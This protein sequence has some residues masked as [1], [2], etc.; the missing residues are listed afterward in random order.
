MKR[1]YLFILL[2]LL[3]LTACNQTLEEGV[4]YEAI[5]SELEVSVSELE[6]QWEA[7]SQD[8]RITCNSY[9]AAETKTSWLSLS[10]KNGKGNGSLQVVVGAN[11]SGTTQR[12]G[13][14]EITDG[15]RTIQVN[16]S[17][18]SQIDESNDKPEEG[19]NP[20]PSY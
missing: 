16:V 10:P 18:S 12:S 8:I 3:M 6:F 9:W 17:Q 19:D 4:E 2:S 20:T 15:I 1:K 13:V 14:I 5:K 7:Q 11:S